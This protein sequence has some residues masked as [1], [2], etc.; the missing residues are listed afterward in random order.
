M[1]LIKWMASFSPWLLVILSSM[2][3]IWG[4]YFAKYWSTNQKTIF[5]LLGILGYFLAGFFYIPSL[6]KEGLIITSVLWQVITTVGLLVIGVA[7]FHE[8]LTALQWAGVGLG[9][10]SVTVLA[11]AI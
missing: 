3:V 1:G 2:A 5:Y 11:F 10:A 4:D 8:T 9:I 7:I 6:L